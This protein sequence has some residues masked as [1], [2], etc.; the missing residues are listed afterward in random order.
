[1]LNSPPLQSVSGSYWSRTP[2]QLLNELQATAQ[3]LASTEAEAR[4]RKYGR[5]ILRDE[6]DQAWWH[7]WLGQFRSPLVLILLFAAVISLVVQDWLDAVIILA[8]VFGSALLGFVQEHRASN[9][10]RRLRARV[11]VQ[12]TVWRDGTPV[13]IPIAQV[14]PGDIVLLAAGS[15]IPGAKHSTS[16]HKIAR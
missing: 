14:V 3:G 8:I 12:A 4:L 11:A 10:V 7:L 13:R 16:K 5:N 6:R 9:A 15:L 1:M 2:A